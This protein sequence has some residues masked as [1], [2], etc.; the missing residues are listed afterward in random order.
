MDRI[1]DKGNLTSGEGREMDLDRFH[2]LNKKKEPTGVFDNEILEYFRENVQI[3]VIGRVPY[4]YH[5]GVFLPD[6]SEAETKSIIRGLIYPQFVKAPTLRRVYE[7]IISAVEFQ[8]TDDEMNLYPPEW[9]CF[10]NGFYDPIGRR[11]VPHDPKYRATNQIPHDFDPGKDAS[12]RELEKWFSFIFEEKDDR[13]MFL[14]FAGYCMTRD[15]R[16]QKFMI[17]CGEGGTGKSTLIRLLEDVVGSRNISSVSLSELGQRFASYDLLGKLVNSC[18][19]LEISAL[20]DT[21]TL[22]K[23]LGEDN[24]KGEA[25]GKQPV[26][27]KSYAKLLFSTNELPVVKTE[28]TNGFYRRLLILN[29]NKIPAEKDPGFLEKLEKDLDYFIHICVNALERMY[30]DGRLVES[31]SSVEAVRRLRCESDTVEAFLNETRCVVRGGLSDKARK[32]DLFRLYGVY[33]RVSDRQPLKKHA[34]FRALRAKGFQEVKSEGVWHFRGIFYPE[35]ASS[36]LKNNPETSFQE[37]SRE[38]MDDLPF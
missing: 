17:L 32:S 3:L 11:M 5:G 28:R 31:V 4:I 2:F 21:S 26:F 10:R 15:T 37:L 1:G 30:E 27:F 20:E 23:L 12:G 14:R 34:F 16:Q 35:N 29:M 25:K 6:L 8:V 36:W 38:E 19:D 22:K 7:L 33:C 13:E 18:A 9:I 24:I